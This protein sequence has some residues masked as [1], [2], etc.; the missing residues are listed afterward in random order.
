MRSSLMSSGSSTPITSGTVEVTGSA[1]LALSSDF[2]S[3]SLQVE[4][5]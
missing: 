4:T 3:L 5:T 2:E 1:S